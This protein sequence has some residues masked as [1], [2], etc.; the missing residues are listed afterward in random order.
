M[1][2]RIPVRLKKEPLLEAIWEIRFTGAKVPVADLLP[3]MLFQLLSGKY[4]TAVKLPVANI[5]APVVEHDPN[6]RY[7]PKIRLEEG[8]QA[9]QVG[10]HVVSLSC[11]RPYSGWNRF[12][13]DIR[14][15]AKAVQKTGVVDRLE[16]FSLKYIDLIELEKPV[17]LAHLNLKLRMGEHELAAKP[18]QLRTEIK[19]NDL[20]HIIQVISPAEVDMP[21]T[22][23]RLKG[24]LVDIDS[25]KLI[26]DGEGESWETLYMRLDD[27]HASCK[28]MF[29][30]ILRSKTVESLEPEYEG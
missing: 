22:E 26:A 15:I 17:G 14:E 21:G 1:K 2:N 7:L 29:F 5:P 25:I 28:N 13:A 4:S 19:E 24:I 16:R 3:G 10:D 30:G 20:I 11:R 9:I 18:V 12:S 23:G 27:V 8:N 6:L